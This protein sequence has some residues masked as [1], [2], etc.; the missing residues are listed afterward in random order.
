MHHKNKFTLENSFCKLY[1]YA[2]VVVAIASIEFDSWRVVGFRKG[3]FAHISIYGDIIK[4]KNWIYDYLSN[5]LYVSQASP[6]KGEKVIKN[7]IIEMGY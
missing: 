2:C 5:I 1:P 6:I 7:I 4:H 3:L